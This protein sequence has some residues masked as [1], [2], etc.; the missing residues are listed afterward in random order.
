MK[1]M[2]VRPVSGR[3]VPDP[4]RGD[5]LPEGGR[6]VPKSQWWMRRLGDGDVV[7]VPER[8]MSQAPV[9]NKKGAD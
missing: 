9:A 1:T 3:M 6:V 7:E 2:R 4:D 8:A 5:V